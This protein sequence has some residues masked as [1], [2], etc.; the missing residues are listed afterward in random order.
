MGWKRFVIPSVCVV[1]TLLAMMWPALYN[2]QPIMFPD[3]QAYIRVADSC[4][5]KITGHKSQW[6]KSATGAKQVCSAAAAAKPQNAAPSK[7]VFLG[8]S[9]YYGAIL[10]LGSAMMRLWP[11]AIFHAFAAMLAICLTLYEFYGFRWK[12][13]L[14]VCAGLAAVTP[15]AFF[16]S[17]L[18]PDIFAGITILAMANLFVFADTM[19]RW[20]IVTWTALLGLSVLVHSSHLMLAFGFLMVVLMYCLV[21][22]ALLWRKAIV[23]A[24]V[25][26]A[27]GIVGEAVFDFSI[28]HVLGV[29]AIRP[30]HIMARVLADGPGAAFLKEK[31]PG[32]G[33]AACAFVKLMPVRDPDDFLWSLDP[34]LGGF[35]L[36]DTATKH[37]LGKEQFRFLFAVFRYDPIGQIYASLRDAASQFAMIG[38]GEFN[39]ARGDTFH[40]ETYRCKLPPAVFANLSES[41]FWRNAMPTVFFTALT[42]FSALAALGYVLWYFN[43]YWNNGVFVKSNLGI[44]V[45]LVLGGLLANAAICGALS[46]PHDRYQTRIIWLL[47]FA[48]ILLS[49]K[50][51]RG[52][53]VLRRYTP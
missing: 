35:A 5:A 22:R 37:A 8:R 46:T 45:I 36:A 25:G 38:L 26:I 10:Y 33:F 20:R 44:F 13:F 3:T 7:V 42:R 14:L 40:A 34:H 23:A 27:V 41:S 19:P 18:M 32:A 51:E 30:P 16:T 47:P 28:Q 1:G 4:V 12:F 53:F 2:G 52:A 21:R 15:L 11:S 17:F 39:L 43:R 24:V 49:G 29:D 31:C 6:S 9:V 50:S 48:A